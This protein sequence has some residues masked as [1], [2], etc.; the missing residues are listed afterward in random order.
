MERLQKVIAQ[1]GYCSRRKAEEWIASGKV[2]VNGETVT[3]MGYKVK[4]GD[5][6]TVNGKLLE[7]ENKVYYLLYKPKGVISAV[8]DDRGRRCVTDLLE[9]VKERVYPVGRLDYDTTG[10]L[11]LTNDGDFANLIMHPRS[12][13]D[14]VY[15]VTL[16]GLID[17]DALHQLESGIY[18]DGVKTLPCKI[19]VTH[20]DIKHKSTSLM[21]KLH[22][23]KNRQ[24]KRMFEAVGFTVTRLHRMSCG[25]LNLKGMKPGEYRRIKPQEVKRLR[26]LA[27]QS[28]Q[29]PY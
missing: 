18:L 26:H 13:L 11:I 14:K 9:D 23:G 28:T 1:S 29:K 12:H 6:I 27:Q 16:N 17:G 21:I 15:E 20:K 22:E 5:A 10:L 4:Q 19:K 8:H 3:E 24:V 25:E 2:Q 7:K